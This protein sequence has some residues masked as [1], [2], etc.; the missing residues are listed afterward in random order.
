MVASR[1]DE[2]VVPP[3]R[4][5]RSVAGLLGDLARETT[6]LFRQEVALA[7]AE[8]TGKV[9]QMGTGAAEM[10]AGGFIIYAGFLALLVAAILGLAHV[11][12]PWLAALIVGVVTLLVGAAL[13][14]KGRRD[15]EARNLMP[16]RTLRTL[17]DDAAW[18]REQMR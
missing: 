9:S 12:A 7:K 10:V 4:H 11:V 15:V 3:L 1:E 8:V 13:V 2:G 17:R 16:D 14:F 5:E 6:R 18:A